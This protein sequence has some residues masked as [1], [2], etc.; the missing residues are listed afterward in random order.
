MAK[1]KEFKFGLFTIDQGGLEY[2][3]VQAVEAKSEDD[4]D[5]SEEEQKL[6]EE[7]CCSVALMREADCKALRDKLKKD[8]G[9]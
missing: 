3:G 2:L 6:T 7:Y 1:K 9:D 4:I 8:W 5:I